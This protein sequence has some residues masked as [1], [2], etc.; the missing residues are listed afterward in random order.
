MV[1]DVTCAGIQLLMKIHWELREV[2]PSLRDHDGPVLD[3]ALERLV[4]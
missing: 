3:L 2:S 1:G 4:S